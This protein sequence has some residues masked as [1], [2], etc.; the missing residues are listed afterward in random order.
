MAA[1]LAFGGFLFDRIPPVTAQARPTSVIR[2][3]LET[4]RDAT[5]LF[6]TEVDGWGQW[7]TKEK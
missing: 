5:P 4:G 7:I 3:N 2:H 1:Y 6:Y